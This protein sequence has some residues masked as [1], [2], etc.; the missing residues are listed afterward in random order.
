MSPRSKS[1]SAQQFFVDNKDPQIGPGA[2]EWR[3]EEFVDEPAQ[4]TVT[5]QP[6]SRNG[7]KDRCHTHTE[8]A[9]PIIMMNDLQ[10]SE[11]IKSA[12]EMAAQVVAQAAEAREEKEKKQE[13][14]D[15]LL[16]EMA[17]EQQL[18]ANRELEAAAAKAALATHEP[19]QPA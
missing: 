14:E 18:Q 7:G 16:L 12:L 9:I 19:E 13:E 6:E 11:S 17:I 15:T 1:A 4:P 8:V 10:D 3:V 2:E 5:A